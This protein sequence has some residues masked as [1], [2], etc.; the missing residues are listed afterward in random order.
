MLIINLPIEEVGEENKLLKESVKTV[1]DN[2]SKFQ[3][4]YAGP[5]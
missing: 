1:W 2:I 5:E 4:N 3:Y